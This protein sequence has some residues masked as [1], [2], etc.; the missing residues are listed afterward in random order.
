MT[1]RSTHGG[2]QGQTRKGRTYSKAGSDRMDV[3]GQ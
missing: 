3:T 2:V 1:G